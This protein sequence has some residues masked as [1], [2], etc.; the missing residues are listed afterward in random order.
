MML[1][2]K[3][4]AWRDGEW[5]LHATDDAQTETRPIAGAKR[6]SGCNGQGESDHGTDAPHT[7]E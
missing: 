7:R 2:P 1:P 4:S 3:R 6:D 5:D